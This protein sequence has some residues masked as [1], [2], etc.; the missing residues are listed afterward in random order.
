MC[1]R[2]VLQLHLDVRSSV[3]FWGEGTYGIMWTHLC[4]WDIF[5][6]YFHGITI[7]F[8]LS[9]LLP[10]SLSC[11][12]LTITAVKMRH[13]LPYHLHSSWKTWTDPSLVVCD[14]VN[15]GLGGHT[16]S[17][18]SY[19]DSSAGMERREKR[20]KNLKP[21]QIRPPNCS[22]LLWEKELINAKQRKEMKS[23]GGGERSLEIRQSLAKSE[24]WRMRVKDFKGIFTKLWNKLSTKWRLWTP[25]SCGLVL[26]LGS[27]EE[28]ALWL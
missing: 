6:W 4:G 19:F 25:I 18:S 28:F 24:T 12:A 26:F 5:I 10:I 20:N 22:G 16:F 15:K 8:Y 21:Q 1:V 27:S 9:C 17:I 7:C 11:D 14:T 23:R 13:V 3:Y 2:L